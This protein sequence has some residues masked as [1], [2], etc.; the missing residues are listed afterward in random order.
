MINRMIER[1]SGIS[2]QAALRDT[3][4]RRLLVLMDLVF[5]M[6]NYSLIMVK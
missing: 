3:M 4:R 1:D 2:T 6:Q 5:T